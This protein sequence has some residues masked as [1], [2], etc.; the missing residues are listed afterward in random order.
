MYSDEVMDRYQNPVKNSKMEDYDIKIDEASTTCGDKIIL[1]IK[2]DGERIKDMTWEGEGCIL[3]I[4][5]T[6]LFCENSVGKEING[7]KEQDDLSFI[8]SFPVKIS[9]GRINCVMLP[10]RAFRRGTRQ[11]GRE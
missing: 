3:S 7:I 6:D 10:L 9:P 4:V 1:Y 2:T 5:S 8:E 11:P